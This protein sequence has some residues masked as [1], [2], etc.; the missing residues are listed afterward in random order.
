MAHELDIT[1]GQAS[2]ADARTD[3]WHGLG[4]QV[5][6]LMT[7]EEALREANLAGWNVRKEPVF[8]SIDTGE[9]EPVMQEV[10]GKF[11]TVRTNPVN[12]KPET[13]GIVGS[14]YHIIQNEESTALLN[15]LTDESGAHFETAG[16]LRGGRDTFVTMKLPEAIELDVPGG[17]KDR[18]ELYIAALNN[19][20]GDSAYRL[21]VTPVRIVCKNTQ[22]AAVTAARSSW[23]IRHTSGALDAIQEA[24][25]SLR[26]TFKYVA[27]FE[28]QVKRM[29]E[30]EVERDTA[31]ALLKRVFDVKGAPTKRV[32]N[33]RMEHVAAVLAG[34]ES[35]T[36]SMLGHTRYNVY[37]S[38]TEY[39]DHKWPTKGGEA[40]G[41]APEKALRGGFAALKARAFQ[42]TA[43]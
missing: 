25:D 13:L 31:E 4:Q 29:I 5:G 40:T 43:V 18:T 38:V 27:A 9:A 1:E 20:D 32:E 41:V 3:A 16:A 35:E 37:N 19:H 14:G 23:S 26:L 7:A 17:G 10:E 8:A 30:A 21:L 28:E 34:T 22:N 11:A 12:G 33:N 36:N 39:V 42:L 15:A 24:R 6:H 2:F